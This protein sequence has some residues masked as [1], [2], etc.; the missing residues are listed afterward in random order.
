MT[1]PGR[2]VAINCLEL[3]LRTGEIWPLGIFETKPLYLGLETNHHWM[4]EILRVPSQ[5]PPTPKKGLVEGWEN[6]HHPLI[7]PAIKAGYFRGWH[8]GGTLRFPRNHQ[9][10]K[11]CPPSHH[12]AHHRIHR[13]S[14]GWNSEIFF[15]SRKLGRQFLLF[16][17]KLLIF[18]D[19]KNSK[20][21]ISPLDMC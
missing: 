4:M 19:G 12:L 13:L 7:R 18:A 5:L 1:V 6:H 2:L 10:Q 21:T 9:Q 17:C 3:W 20:S 15:C 8:S 14:F 11:C 16:Q